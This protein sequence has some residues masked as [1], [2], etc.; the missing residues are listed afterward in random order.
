MQQATQG[1]PVEDFPNV[2]PLEK[3]AAGK[4]IQV[5]TP[6]NAPTA[7]LA[8]QG[9]AGTAAAKLHRRNPR[10]LS[11][12]VRAGTL[13]ISLRSP[14]ETIPAARWQRRSTGRL[15]IH[16]HDSASAFDLADGRESGEPGRLPQPLHNFRGTVNSNS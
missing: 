4:Q 16:K 11:A 1:M 2:V 13:V 10:A 5:D 7:D 8:E 12:H 15:G 9:L 3:L 6:D 14:P